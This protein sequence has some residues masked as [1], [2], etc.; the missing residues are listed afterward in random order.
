[1]VARTITSRAA[2]SVSLLFS[3]LFAGF[4]IT[5]LVLELSMRGFDGSVYAQVR[6]VELVA[7]DVFASVTLIP[8]LIVTALLAALTI[9]QK[10]A[11]RLL[12]VG[13][14]I[15]LL[16]ILGTSLLVNVPI[17]TDQLEW[18]VAA[19]PADWATV[20]D[21]W[22]SAHAVRTGAAVIAVALLSATAMLSS[23][24]GRGPG[25]SVERDRAGAAGH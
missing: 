19:P 8:A 25:A 21:R 5:V 23:S 9:R 4:L 22:Q 12:P 17:N 6:Q 18:N 3:G 1:M 16:L 15:M 11:A 14:L 13:A 24:A 7:M 20:R 10:E 2:L